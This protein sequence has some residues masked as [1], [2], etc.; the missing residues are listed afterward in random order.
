MKLFDDGATDA[1]AE[2]D[3]D[4]ILE[5]RNAWALN[6]FDD[7][8]CRAHRSTESPLSDEEFAYQS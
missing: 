7:L 2:R 8:L 3:E 5:T 6:D 4:D 1:L